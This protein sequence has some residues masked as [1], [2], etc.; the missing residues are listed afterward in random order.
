VSRSFGSGFNTLR[1]SE[2]ATEFLTAAFRFPSGDLYVSQNVDPV[3]GSPLVIGGQTHRAI[4]LEWGDV[5]SDA[6]HKEKKLDVDRMRIVLSNAPVLPGNVNFAQYLG[7][8]S[9]D[10]LVDVY[11]NYESDGGTINQELLNTFIFV[12]PTSWSVVRVEI[13]LTSAFEVWLSQPVLDVIDAEYLTDNGSIAS[14][15]L[16]DALT[17]DAIGQVV[18]L[19]FGEMPWVPGILVQD[20]RW[21]VPWFGSSQGPLL[22]KE[23]YLFAECGCGSFDLDDLRISSD[24]GQEAVPGVDV[25]LDGDDESKFLVVPVPN[26]G[27][28]ADALQLNHDPV[29]GKYAYWRGPGIA[30]LFQGFTVPPNLVNPRIV[31][32][33][34]PYMTAAGYPTP[35]RM[36]IG[37]GEIGDTE[38][39]F[40]DLLSF[41]TVGEGLAFSELQSQSLI[42]SGET[43]GSDDPLN[44]TNALFSFGGVSVEAGQR[45]FLQMGIPEG[46]EGGDGDA[47]SNPFYTDANNYWT[48]WLGQ[49]EEDDFTDPTFMTGGVDPFSWG[50]NFTYDP[51]GNTTMVRGAP[52][53][54]EISY[55]YDGIIEDALD[56]PIIVELDLDEPNVF[57]AIEMEFNFDGDDPQ[58]SV[59]VSISSMDADR[60][61]RNILKEDVSVDFGV[62]DLLDQ[63][64][65]GRADYFVQVNDS[66]AVTGLTLDQA[67]AS[68]QILGGTAGLTGALWA[69]LGTRRILKTFAPIALDAGKHWVVIKGNFDVTKKTLQGFALTAKPRRLPYGGFTAV[70]HSANDSIGTAHVSPWPPR[71][72]SQVATQPIY[73]DQQ[74]P[75]GMSMRL[76][77]VQ[78]D[79]D[80]RCLLSVSESLN[81]ASSITATVQSGAFSFS[82]VF[83]C[84]L[85]RAGIPAE[86]RGSMV[87]GVSGRFDGIVDAQ[88]TFKELFLV[89]AFESGSIVDW[90]A[91]LFVVRPIPAPGASAVATIPYAEIVTTGREP[92]ITVERTDPMKIANVVDLRW[93]RNLRTGKYNG[94]T[95]RRDEASIG[96]RGKRMLIDYFTCKY[97]RTEAHAEALADL[98]LPYHANP[99]RR[100]RLVGDRVNVHLEKA[101]VVQIA[102]DV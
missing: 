94:Y 52:M 43:F 71:A 86:R 17:E 25:D 29:V 95:E 85:D 18:P 96:K 13:D 55:V 57:D 84:L 19:V 36:A 41:N 70:S 58:G 67:K 80:G 51:G 74:F 66:V 102:S 61:G 83:T 99:A 6:D 91:G 75:V 44:G 40:K 90:S 78:F 30:N 77:A 68:A 32:I 21:I 26:R 65:T 8:G 34:V 48:A 11:I 33:N 27:E 97:V 98:Y 35:L 64:D 37:R 100:A 9:E 60:P 20:S 15:T 12:A 47:G 54:V 63:T 28:A 88:T 1:N 38:N 31:S 73:D 59:T 2:H 42:F 89:L 50:T 16:R 14:P 46:G 87:F 24:N 93:A 81:E 72:P 3:T 39:G 101:D 56:A 49:K 76:R 62:A 5:G 69:A 7:D 92:Q 4:V 10:T 23:K 82:D 45:L 79:I 53:N 22:T